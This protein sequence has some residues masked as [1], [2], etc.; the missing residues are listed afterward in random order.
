MG[1][2]RARAL[3]QPPP[4]ENGAELAGSGAGIWPNFPPPLTDDMDIQLRRDI[5]VDV[6]EEAAKLDRAV[7]FVA[8]ANHR[9]DRDVER[10]KQ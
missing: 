6:I 4:S 1:S 8:A 7:A 2:A 9:S 5:G 10:G 3:T